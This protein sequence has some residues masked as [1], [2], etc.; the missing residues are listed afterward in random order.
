MKFVK[1]QYSAKLFSTALSLKT[2]GKKLNKQ[3]YNPVEPKRRN[4][5]GSIITRK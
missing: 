3:Y 2:L 1:G 5:D 4:R